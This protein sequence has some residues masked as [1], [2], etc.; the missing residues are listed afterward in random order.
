MLANPATKTMEY[1]NTVVLVSLRMLTKDVEWIW[2]VPTGIVS[3]TPTMWDVG[4]GIQAKGAKHK[5]KQQRQAP[6]NKT[7]KFFS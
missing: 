6:S 3:S 5:L 2:N 4:C 1:L 7:N